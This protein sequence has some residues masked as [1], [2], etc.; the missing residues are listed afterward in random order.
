MSLTYGGAIA[1]LLAFLAKSFGIE[2]LSNDQV[3]KTVEGVLAIGGFLIACYGRWRAGGVK[4]FGA[5]I[6]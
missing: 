5:K 4:W 2:A 1:M 3:E 6:K